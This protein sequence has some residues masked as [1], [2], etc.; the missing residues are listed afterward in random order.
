M[1]ARRSL[2][3]QRRHLAAE[4]A[5][6]RPHPVHRANGDEVTH[7]GPDGRPS[8][9]G[10]FSKCLPHDD[11]G[12]VD[13]GLY[14]EWVRAIDSGDPRDVA[15][16][17]FVPAGP[18]GTTPWTSGIDPATPYRGW[19]SLGA[20]H[21]FDLQG[22]DAQSVTMPPAPALDS[23][24]LVAEMAELYWM[25]LCRDVPF[26]R[27]STDSTVGAA[28][29][30]LRTLDWFRAGRPTTGSTD[31]LPSSQ[32]RRRLVRGGT[33]G[34][35][36]VGE[37]F[38]GTAP[39]ERVG[40]YVSQF[41]LVG[42]HRALPG[43]GAHDRDAGHVAYGA[44]R[45]DQ[46]V[47]TAPAG[48]DYMTD[49]A[50]WLDVQRGA[51]LNGREDP[52]T[53]YRFITTGRDLATYVHYDALYEAYLNACLLL[54]GSGAPFDPGL[55]LQRGDLLD[56]QSGFAQFGGPHVLTLVTEVATR[57]LKAVRYQKY[58]VH[59]R[60][61]PEVVAARLNRLAT[62][63]DPAVTDRL[64]VLRP[65]LDTLSDSA[66]NLDAHVGG[67]SDP[68]LLPMAFPEG[69][70]AH[71]SYGAGHAT[72]AGA[73][74][75]V[76]K[77]WFDAGHPLGYAFEANEDGSALVDVS[78]D[79]PAL[80]VGGELDKVAAN[81]A[82]GRGWGGV[83]YYSDYIES[84]RLGEQVALGLLEEQKLCYGETWS[85]SVPLLDGSVVRL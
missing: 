38:R 18:G 43:A 54:L 19:E 73:C 49:F 46:R 72:V 25:A 79:H 36:E 10:S 14:A 6:A 55:P 74:V 63:S 13:P 5:A 26:S 69:S 34:D 53:G 66:V 41:L 85:M 3:L 47:R 30:S 83:H 75:T 62:S 21:T 17:D 65:M 15:A 20:G 76:L 11:D 82:L 81:V 68:W 35:L 77:A 7:R 4:V 70:P 42:N 39:G 45:I 33:A 60:C 1:T 58:N 56:K 48:V 52:Y 27:W 2:S 28:R 44:V 57:A 59:R 80:T 67:G 31:V 50:T 71:P 8:Y 61:R 78:A 84:F 51:R 9:V 37:L 24:E 29:A 22:P 40:P 12:F 16:L 32:A 64:E 23:E